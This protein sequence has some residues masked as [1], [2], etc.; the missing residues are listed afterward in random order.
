M[1]TAL[2]DLIAN[3]NAAELELFAD[4]QNEDGG[5]NHDLGHG[6]LD[7]GAKPVD[8]PDLCC[9][10][11]IQHARHAWTTGDANF[12]EQAWP[13]VKKAVEKHARWADAGKGVAQVGDL[14]T[15]YDGYKYI[16]TTAYLGTLWIAALKIARQWARTEDDTEFIAAT[17]RWESAADERL[18]ADLWNGRFYR[19]YASQGNPSNE[20]SH[21]GMLAGEYYTRLLTG[22]DVLPPERLKSCVD[23]LMELNCVDGLAVPADEAAPDGGAGS[24]YGWLP[25][26][27]AFALAP[28]ALVGHEKTVQVWRPMIEAMQGANDAHPCDTRLMYRP[29]T[30]EPSWGAY[31]MTAPASWLVYDAQLDFC[32]LPGPGVLRF[33]PWQDGDFALVHP[34]FWALGTRRGNDYSVDMVAVHGGAP[35]RINWIEVPANIETLTCA[36]EAKGAWRPNGVYRQFAVAP[37]DLAMNTRLS[38]RTEP[39]GARCAD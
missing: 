34:R 2:R 30:G 18:E 20:N 28:C 23:A 37:L 39:I 13:K 26:I 4:Y 3:P 7:A 21:A 17:E 29:Q 32:C 5:V 10:F 38:W 14:G 27:E 35:V 24:L 6:H 16:G 31:Y 8:W 11:V 12:A 9:S 36:N 15:S 33:S 1:T 19:A 22:E 25:Y